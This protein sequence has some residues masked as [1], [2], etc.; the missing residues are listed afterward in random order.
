MRGSEFLPPSG[1]GIPAI[2]PTMDTHN[3]QQP[4]YTTRDAHVYLKANLPRS[5]RTDRP[6]TVRNIRF[7]TRSEFNYG[8]GSS[9]PPDDPG[10]LVCVADLVG[11]FGLTEEARWSGE[12][13]PSQRGN[14]VAVMFDGCT[15]NL[16]LVAMGPSVIERPG[17]PEPKPRLVSRTSSKPKGQHLA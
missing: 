10:R 2:V 1:P 11:A 14:P 7:T 15:G 17:P 5:L 16:L 4:G 6:W 13:K 9:G 12:P 8:L 3:P